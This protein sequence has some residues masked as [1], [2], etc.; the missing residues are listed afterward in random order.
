MSSIGILGNFN[1]NNAHAWYTN[2]S[3]S[4]TSESE[5]TMENL[6]LAWDEASIHINNLVRKLKDCLA[7]SPVPKSIRDGMRSF[8]SSLGDYTKA[9]ESDDIE[10]IAQTAKMVAV[11]GQTIG[12]AIPKFKEAEDEIKILGKELLEFSN[13]FRSMV[14]DSPLEYKPIE[15]SDDDKNSVYL[16]NFQSIKRNLKVLADEHERHDQRVKNL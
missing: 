1:I 12:Q 11:Y 5:E 15:K 14:E 16:H 13:K 6:L 3:Q 9:A 10:K 4:L 2:V 7:D 8:D